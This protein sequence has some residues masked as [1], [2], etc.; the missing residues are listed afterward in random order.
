MKTIMYRL[1]A[2]MYLISTCLLLSIF[3]FIKICFDINYS[4]TN[5]PPV[6]LA[7]VFTD[8]DPYYIE[9]WPSQYQPQQSA[10]ICLLQAISTMHKCQWKRFNSIPKAKA[11]RLHFE[12]QRRPKNCSSHPREKVLLHNVISTQASGK[13]HR[14]QQ[15][16]SLNSRRVRHTFSSSSR[17]YSSL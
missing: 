5:L 13:K 7:D 15:I 10:A 4:A 12:I 8:S 6:S 11:F 16:I 14:I 3:V 17:A 2:L 1:S 9:K